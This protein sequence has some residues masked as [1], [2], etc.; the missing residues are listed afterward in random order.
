MSMSVSI[1]A[2][3]R[4]H[5]QLK[6]SLKLTAL[7]LAHLASRSGVVR[8]SYGLLARKTGQS[9]K[10][11][12]RHVHRLVA[13]GLVVK[14]TMRLTFTRFAVNQYRFLVG[15]ET[16]HKRSTPTL[17]QAYPTEGKNLRAREDI[18][19]KPPTV[20]Q[21]IR[22]W[23]ERFSTLVGLSDAFTRALGGFEQ[24]EDC[25]PRFDVPMEDG[26]VYRVEA[27]DAND[28]TRKVLDGQGTE[29][30]QPVRPAPGEGPVFSPPRPEP[31]SGGTVSI[32]RQPTPQAPGQQPGLID[33]V[34][35]WFAQNVVPGGVDIAKKGL[36]P[37]ATSQA[38]RYGGAAVPGLRLLPPE[39]REGLGSMVGTGVNMALGI[40]EP[41][42]TNLAV[43]AV[44]PVSTRG[45]ARQ[46]VKRL[47]GAAAAGAA[48]F[49]EEAADIPLRL[50]RG[51]QQA[52]VDKFFTGARA[53]NTD[54]PMT[55]TQSTMQRLLQ[56]EA[57]VEV[58]A[59]QFT[60][61]QNMSRQ[62]NA[63]LGRRGGQVP[64]SQLDE[65]RRRIGA[66]INVA[67]N[68][69]EQTA[70]RAMYAGIMTDLEQAAAQMPGDAADQLRQG[71]AQSRRLFAADDLSK[72][73]TG[74]TAA[75]REVDEF[76]R[77]NFGRIIKTLENP[78]G[79]QQHLLADFLEQHPQEKAEV[80]ALL[81][82]M[83]TRNVA[84]LPPKGRQYGSGGF[85]AT[86]G[87]GFLATKA[88]NTVLG[89]EVIDPTTG[90]MLAGAGGEMISRLL[91]TKPGRT[92]LKQMYTE[93]GTLNLTDLATQY[94][95]QTTRANAPQ[96][97]DWFSGKRP[98]RAQAVT[99][100][101]Y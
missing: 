17:G 65:W 43:S 45:T 98:T 52:D 80:L 49:A 2:A 75:P 8:I 5:P 50:S 7:E 94:L 19:Q 68:S 13:L 25:M 46:V 44:T 63:A 36:I 96:A 88:L 62:M 51:V 72:V 71:I 81:H 20:P 91:M 1:L 66:R 42:L 29:V 64:V 99:P 69:E 23:L 11:M 31:P 74:A 59:L 37:T 60:E 22:R 40:E 21:E 87:K 55:A 57:D 77:V 12:I 83:N 79:E 27:T 47:P 35:D 9:I 56:A 30:P 53:L 15:V 82:D 101:P 3:I 10:T 92:M 39:A 85:W 73:I 89:E 100:R 84:L 95:G 67:E 6:G 34:I 61:I 76:Q 38:L 48:G 90:G 26:K 97:V 32:P 18:P 78:R 86:S 4:S 33:P 93:T 16:L 70:L 58:P 28:A 14:H 24:E 41:S 54:V